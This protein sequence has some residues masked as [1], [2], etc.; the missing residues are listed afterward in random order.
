MK[1]P[2]IVLIMTDQHRFDT[3][4]CYGNTVIETP[5]LD[6]LAQEGT[7]FASAYS[8]TPSCVPARTSL[9][10]GMDPWHTGILGTGKGQGKMGGNFKH[11][12]PG[13]LS[14]SGYCT[15]G[16]GKMNFNPQ[17]ALNGFHQTSLDESGR[18]E[19]P[20][21]VSDYAAWFERNKT[22]DYGSVDHGIDWNSWMSRPFHAPEFLHPVNWTINESI[23]L[24]EKRD[25]TAPFFLKTSFSRP[26]SPYD[27]VPITSICIGRSLC[28]PPTSENGPACMTSRPMHNRRTPG[29]ASART[30]KCGGHEPDI[31][32]L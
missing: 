21:F 16:V 30:R 23:R 29:E 5:N 9:L 19:S 24:L 10:T 27:P 26:H 20:G 3:L 25:P 4:G 14:K 11:T 28:P 31:T 2:N 6:S 1:R 22:G 12:L 17:R 13:E 32:G 8:S 18:V 15:L 7:V